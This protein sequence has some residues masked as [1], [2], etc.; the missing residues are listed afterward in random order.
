[1]ASY[2]GIASGQ[3]PRK[4]YFGT[5]R[6]FP[7]DNCDWSWSEQKAVGGYRTYLGVQ[8]F[9]GAYR[10]NG[11]RL[12]PTWGGSMF[13]A[14]MVP[15]FVPEEKWGKRSW[16]LTHPTYVRSQIHHGMDE[17]E[18]GYWGFSPSNNPAGGYREYGVDPIG[19]EPNGYAS[20]QE[21]TFVDYGYGDVPGAAAGA[22][23]LRA[24]CGDPARV[25]PRLPIRARGGA[26][27]PCQSA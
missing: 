10:Y 15:L 26:A 8:V 9:E 3:I 21:R 13:E 17:A 23:R 1:M 11:Q 14:L 18:Y 20:D 16:A 25:V 6:T 27:E 5:W 22:G 19:M 24:G 12:I 7:G 2:L 4:H